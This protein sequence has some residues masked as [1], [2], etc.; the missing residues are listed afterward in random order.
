MVTKRIPI[1][2]SQHPQITDEVLAAWIDGDDDELRRLLRPVMP[3]WQS[4]LINL[5]EE[6][7]FPPE[8][9]AAKYWAQAKA[10]RDELQKLAPRDEMRK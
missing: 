5:A 9:G 8:L 6:C 1:K 2:R 10:I 4:S 7:P 3:P